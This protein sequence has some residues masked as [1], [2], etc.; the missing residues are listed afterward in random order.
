LGLR[1]VLSS[2]RQVE[3]LIKSSDRLTA[4]DHIG[5]VEVPLSDIMSNNEKKITSREDGV[6]NADGKPAPGTL[7]WSC[8]YFP[9]TVLQQH[10]VE[11][12]EDPKKV[13]QDIKTDA[14]KKLRE[15][16]SDENGEVEQQ[17]DEDFQERSEEM[18][19]GMAPSTQ[20]PSGILHV[21]VTQI[22]GLEV[23]KVRQSGTAATDDDEESDDLPS[24]Y[25]VIVIN[26]QRVFKTRTKMKAANPFVS[27]IVL[28]LITIYLHGVV[29]VRCRHREIHQ[30]LDQ[31]SGIYCCPGL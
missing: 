22:T 14:K 7:R 3:W 6:A 5:T 17:M 25:C 8:G 15:A 16:P 27:D 18:I 29:V 20:W 19:S 26:H 23:P 21:R 12:E 9:K 4:D 1:Y 31:F 2:C 28:A 10:L 11:H 24:A 13:E 30:R